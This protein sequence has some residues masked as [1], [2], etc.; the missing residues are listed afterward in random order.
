MNIDK[1]GVKTLSALRKSQEQ[2]RRAAKKIAEEQQLNQYIKNAA[3]SILA[4]FPQLKLNVSVN[5]G[6]EFVSTDVLKAKTSLL[7]FADSI[8]APWSYPGKVSK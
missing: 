3:K 2:S 6:D 5:R 7:D 8:W 1:V 4:D